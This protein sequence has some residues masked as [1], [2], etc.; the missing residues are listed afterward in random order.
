[1]YAGVNFV[2]S[3]TTVLIIPLI[4]S[5]S[6][7]AAAGT[8]LS[9]A[10]VGMLLGS[11]AVSAWGGPKRRVPGILIGIVV[12]GGFVALT[13]LRPSVPLIAAGSFLLLASTPIVNTAS[14]VLWQLKVAPAVQGRVFALRRMISQAISP[15]AIV[16]AGPL[17]D[18][19]FEP[20]MADDGALADTV[21]RVIGTGPG[22][23]IGL[24]I[25]LSG[26]GVILMAVAGWLHPKVRHLETDLPDEI[27]EEP[28][29]TAAS[30]APAGSRP[31]TSVPRR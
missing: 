23:G 2:L 14:Q 21:G 19:V 10:G 24:M 27:A 17:A 9:V 25:I 15:I 8:V 28:A 16:A 26:L 6:S 13:G 31:A 12:A 18:R 20:L 30:P 5:F 7:E 1:M 4:V 29:E 11:L 3:F 22:R